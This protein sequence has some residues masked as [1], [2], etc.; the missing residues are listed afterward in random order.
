MEIQLSFILDL[1]TRWRW[2]VSFTPWPRFTPGD[3]TP[4]THCIGDW[5]SLISSLD[6]E[7]R[8]KI[9]C[10]CRGY[11]YCYFRLIHALLHIT[12]KHGRMNR[13]RV[14]FE[15]AIPLSELFKA[16]VQSWWASEYFVFEWRSRS[17]LKAI[18]TYIPFYFQAQ[19]FMRFVR[20]HHLNRVVKS[21][22]KAV[23]LHTMEALGGRGGIAPTHS[24]PRH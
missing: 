18:N 17:N 7:D 3:M 20:L 22:S 5:V 1:G 21:K 16:E 19:N 4:G 15:P 11:Y 23:P 13:F 9:I 10:L 2:V 24:R 14:G 12:R 6:T 8:G